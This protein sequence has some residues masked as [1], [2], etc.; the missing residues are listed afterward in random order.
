MSMEMECIEH[1]GPYKVPLQFAEYFGGVVSICAN[2]LGCTY[3]DLNKRGKEV[4][5]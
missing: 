4:E 5:L 3:D 1:T 2:I